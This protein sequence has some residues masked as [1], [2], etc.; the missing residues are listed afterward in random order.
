MDITWSADN[1]VSMQRERL[2]IVARVAKEGLAS[3]SIWHVSEREWAFVTERQ[4]VEEPHEG[5]HFQIAPVPLAS[6]ETRNLLPET[7][8]H[9]ILK[10][11][12]QELGP[13]HLDQSVLSM[14]KN[15]SLC[16]PIERHKLKYLSILFIA[17]LCVQRKRIQILC[18][19]CCCWVIHLHVLCVSEQ[20]E[21]YDTPA[22][23][24]PQYRLRTANWSS[25]TSCPPQPLCAYHFDC[26]S[27]ETHELQSLQPYICVSSD[28]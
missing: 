28:V 11:F 22:L 2:N 12:V 26:M 13:A 21:S 5:L 19:C 25:N 8:A 9:A 16:Q 4:T 24:A 14:M 20:E 10:P 18:C 3:G 27:L 17:Y 7:S 6:M 15:H 23:L 1:H